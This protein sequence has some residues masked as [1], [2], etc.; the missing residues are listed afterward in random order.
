VTPSAELDS[1]LLERFASCCPLAHRTLCGRR[2]LLP[3]K[4]EGLYPNQDAGLERRQLVL[5]M[6][7]LAP[8]EESFPFRAEL[9]CL[10]QGLRCDCPTIFLDPHLAEAL[11]RTRLPDDF[12]TDDIKF[13]WPG[14]RLYLSKGLRLI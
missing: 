10:L 12:V 7:V 5:L 1:R 11:S 14:F 6:A 3:R 8:K 2:Y 9:L 13:R 4:Y